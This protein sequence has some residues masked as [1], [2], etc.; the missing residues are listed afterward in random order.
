MKPLILLLALIVAGC[1]APQCVP[2]VTEVKVPVAVPCD[3][4]LPHKPAF[5]VDALEIGAPIDKQMRALRA[6]RQQRNGYELELEAAA[7]AC[8]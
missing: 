3:E 1:A 2:V 5:A 4:P 8:R 7:G 6:E